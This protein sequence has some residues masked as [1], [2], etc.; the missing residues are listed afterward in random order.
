MEVRIGSIESALRAVSYL[1]E[2]CRNGLRAFDADLVH[3][4]VEV[5]QRGAEKP[6]REQK[7]TS[8]RARRA[9]FESA[10]RA[11]SYLGSAPAIAIAPSSPI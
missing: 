5:G 3:A 9:S 1:R 2:H 4:D 8:K 11:A 7:S 10:W 6:N